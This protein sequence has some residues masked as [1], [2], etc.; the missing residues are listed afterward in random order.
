MMAFNGFPERAKFLSCDVNFR[1]DVALD[2]E[3]HIFREVGWA[4]HNKELRDKANH[5]IK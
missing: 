5:K 2:K 1:N 4:T 3:Q